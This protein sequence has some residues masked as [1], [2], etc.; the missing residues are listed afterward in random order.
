MRIPQS[1][2]SRPKM[3]RS[4]AAETGRV[5]A[6]FSEG[7]TPTVPASPGGGGGL[8]PAGCC[9]KVCLPVVGCHCVAESPLC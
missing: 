9:A 7:A 3:N 1:L 8:A 4:K 5:R 6:P 2:P